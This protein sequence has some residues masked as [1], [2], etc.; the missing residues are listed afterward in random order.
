MSEQGTQGTP[1]V[2]DN[3]AEGQY[4]LEVNGEIAYSRYR[5]HGNQLIVYHT[6]VP[7]NLGGRGIG[8]ALMRGL[9]QDARDRH[10]EIVPECEFLAAYLKRHPQY[11]DLVAPAYRAALQRSSGS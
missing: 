11:L 9:L 3:E 5:L 1:Q 6:E 2:R 4:E 10:L 7:E 8:S